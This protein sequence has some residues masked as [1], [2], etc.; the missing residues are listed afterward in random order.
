MAIV[1]PLNNKSYKFFMTFNKILKLCLW[2]K[3]IY[4]LNPFGIGLVNFKEILERRS[5]IR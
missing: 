5:Q 3:Q 2:Y 4:L 1:L